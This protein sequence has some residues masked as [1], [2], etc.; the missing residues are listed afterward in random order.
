MVLSAP[1]TDL[2]AAEE[3]RVCEEAGHVETREAGRMEMEDARLG[4][5]KGA[6]DSKEAI[7]SWGTFHCANCTAPHEGFPPLQYGYN[8]HPMRHLWIHYEWDP[9]VAQYHAAQGFPDHPSSFVHDPWEDG[10]A[11]YEGQLQYMRGGSRYGPQDPNNRLS[12]Y[13]GPYPPLRTYPNDAIPGYY[14]YGTHTQPH[15]QFHQSPALHNSPHPDLTSGMTPGPP[16]QWSHLP[17]AQ[18]TVPWN[19]DTPPK[20][21]VN[22]S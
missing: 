3:G 2:L 9:Y 21:E 8:Y 14:Y 15:L 7:P 12:A 16:Q 6:M 11:D 22:P 13:Q 10:H 19:K 1:S 20:S 5:D 18:S 17:L 4:A